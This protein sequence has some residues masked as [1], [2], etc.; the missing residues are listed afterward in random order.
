M[1]PEFITA[2]TSTSRSAA[3]APSIPDK[4]LTDNLQNKV[5]FEKALRDRSSASSVRER[6]PTSRHARQCAG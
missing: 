5:A 1:I 2:K 4:S 6:K 3:D